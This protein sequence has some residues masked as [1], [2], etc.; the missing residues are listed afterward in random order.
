MSNFESGPDLTKPYS[1]DAT[2]RGEAP[3]YQNA[4]LEFTNLESGEVKVIGFMISPNN[5][6]HSKSPLQ[7]VNRTTAG[8]AVMRSGRNMEQVNV[9]GYLL[10]S[11][12]CQE[13]HDFVEKYYK[14][15]VED[16]KNANNEHTN[17]WGV[18]LIIEGKKHI[19]Y[20]QGFSFQKTSLQPF[21]YQYSIVF[22]SVDDI[23]IHT[24]SDA[25]TYK[26]EPQLGVGAASPSSS[27]SVPPQ[28]EAIGS[29]VAWV[30]DPKKVESAVDS[31]TENKC[32]IDMDNERR[33]LKGLIDKG[34]P[35]EKIWAL[36]QA[37]KYKKLCGFQL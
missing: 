10:D 33:Y 24:S 20:I 9:T 30:L 37:E 32:G 28:Q 27:P 19:G 4:Y 8:W 16:K 23:L 36:Q 5:V 2:N 14:E 18:S 3:G 31:K 29:A 26:Q 22:M 15:Y 12:H 35:G 1:L 17:N 6:S 11:K 21:L 34:T 13:R 7:Q 25:Q